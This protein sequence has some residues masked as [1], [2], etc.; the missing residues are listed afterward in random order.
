MPPVA[1]F[2]VDEKLPADA[3]AFL[4]ALT[5]QTGDV[6]IDAAKA[7]LHLGD[8]YYFLPADQA[9]RVLI[10]V[11]GNP[12]EAVADVL[13]MVMEQFLAKYVSLNSFTETRIHGSARGLVM[14]WP[15]RMGRCATL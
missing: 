3:K 12:P 11:W 8:R 5:P 1:A 7:V 6:R 15:P 13:G 10:Q 2:A 4:R 14:A 9:K